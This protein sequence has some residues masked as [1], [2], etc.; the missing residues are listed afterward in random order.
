MPHKEAMAN[1]FLLAGA[2]F[3]AVAAVLHIGCIVFGAPWYRFFGAGRRMVQ[4]AVSGSWVPAIVTAGITAV[5]ALWAL[6]GLSGAGALARLPF[7]RAAL[8]AIAGIYLL[9]GVAGLAFAAAAPGD[10]GS[11]FWLWS[12]AICLGIGS[13][14]LV[15]TWQVWPQL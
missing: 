5:L 15:G 14:Y 12:S 10:R 6:Y 2:A 3:S 11:K 7:M 1:P 13:L 9:R 4:L 8:C